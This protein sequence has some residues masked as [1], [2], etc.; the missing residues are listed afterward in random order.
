MSR[1]AVLTAARGRHEHLA[2]QRTTLALSGRAPDLRVVVAMGDDEIAGPDVVHLDVGPD[3]PLPVGAA[4]N[5]AAA[6]AIE[7]GADTLVF[8]DVDCLVGPGTLAAYE[9]AVADRPSVVWCGPVTYLRAE[10]RPYPLDALAALDDPHPVR[11][12]PRPGTR[13]TSDDWELFWS[14]SFALSADAWER[15]GGFD[16]TYVGYGAEDTDLGQR[17]RAVGLGLGWVGDAP[18]YHQHH[19]VSDPPVEHVD[20]ILRNGRLFAERWGWWPM[21]GWLEALAGRGLV[22]PDGAGGWQGVPA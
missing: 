7:A 3:D 13:E 21:A 1:L 22:E 10:H 12:A 11:P 4:R 19:P 8:L 17:F 16:E 6:T 5:L 2:A 15:A 14:L 18:A 20:D 9:A